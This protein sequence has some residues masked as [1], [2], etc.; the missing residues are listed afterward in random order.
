MLPKDLKI[1]FDYL[2]SLE[3]RKKFTLTQQLYFKAFASTA[4]N[5]WTRYDL[6]AQLMYNGPC[7]YILVHRN[8][9]LINFVFKDLKLALV[10]DNGICYIEFCLIFRKT[11]KDPNKGKRFEIFQKKCVTTVQCSLYFQFKF[12]VFRMTQIIPSLTATHI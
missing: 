7:S 9:E 8:D 3:G 6:R 2:D 12:I 11:N 4:F 5:L 1:L 10:S